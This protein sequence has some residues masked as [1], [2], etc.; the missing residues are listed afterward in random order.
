[1][2]ESSQHQQE[3]NFVTA[4]YVINAF[5]TPDGV[6]EFRPLIIYG[7]LGYGK[8]TYAFKVGVNVLRRLYGYEE[9]RAWE[10]VKKFT[11]FRPVE[12]MEKVEWID[13]TY[14]RFPFIIWDDAGIWLHAM[15]WHD[16]YV[17]AVQKWLNVARTHLGSIIFTTPTPGWLIGKIRYFP[18]IVSIKIYKKDSE[19]KDLP[20]GVRRAA[21]YKAWLAPDMKKSGV[22]LLWI[23]TFHVR[24]PD[25][26]YA[27]YKPRRD[28]YEKMARDMVR[29]AWDNVSKKK[30][31]EVIDQTPEVTEE[32]LYRYL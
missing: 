14:G 18:N 29:Q 27:W 6:E 20:R 17:V 32:E 8:S 11:V 9:G 25:D 2:E 22:K 28:Q 1:M 10:E 5:R 31:L 21:A 12:F 3:A 24:M 30:K 26:F 23:D 19:G 7:P 16:E 4:G 15:D 13:K